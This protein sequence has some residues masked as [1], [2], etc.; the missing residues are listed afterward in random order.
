V[1]GMIFAR[2][3]IGMTLLNRESPSVAD[4][5]EAYEHLLW[6]Y[7]EAEQRQYAETVQ[8]RA[9]LAQLGIP[10]PATSDA[11]RVAKTDT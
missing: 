7:T 10:V 2:A 6:A 4:I 1:R 5:I 8:L 9:V 3:K 11:P